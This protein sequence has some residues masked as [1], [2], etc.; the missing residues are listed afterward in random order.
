MVESKSQAKSFVIGKKVVLEAWEDVKSDQGAAGVDGESIEDL[1]RD[2]RRNLYKVWNRLSSGSYMPPAVRA[3]Q[4]PKP[5]GLGVRVLGVP[6]VADRVA[7][8]VVKRYLEPGVEP[9]FHP[10]SYGYRPGCSAHD[11][12]RVCRDRCWKYFWVIDL[13]F[14]SFFDSLDHGLVLRA[15][16][17]HTDQRWILLCVERWL[18]A[19]VQLEDGTEVA[20]DRGTPRGPSISPLLA[21]IFLH[22]AFDSWMARELPAVPFER[23]VDDVVAH[24]KS[25]RQAQF[26]LERIRQRVR[27]LGLELNLDKTQIVYCKDSKRKGSHERERFDFLGYTFRP[28]SSR[29]RKGAMFV[30]FSP[31]V[32]DEAAKK[33][34]RTIR[35]WRLHLW[36]G[37]HLTQIARAINPIVR[38]WIDYYGKFYP[39]MLAPSLRSIDKYLVRWAMRKYKRLTRRYMRAWEFL[40]GV[41]AREPNLFAHWQIIRRSGR[42]VGAV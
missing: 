10:D 9:V 18:K 21:N 25:E 23:Y 40:D 27:S 26:V 5:H 4:V 6:T 37:T 29:D 33:I 42:M 20:R 22:Y 36:S 2:H 28:R 13:D 15:V 41:A 8:T 30:N 7:Q 3:V 16:A 19:P 1:E 34:R 39:S 24:C 31:A 11:A 38:G 17:A 14:Q 32:S 35:R 12:L